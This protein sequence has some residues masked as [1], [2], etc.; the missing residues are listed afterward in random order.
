MFQQIFMS[1]INQKA[2]SI[3]ITGICGVF[4]GLIVLSLFLVLMNSFFANMEKKRIAKGIPV[5]TDE[6]VAAIA[7]SLYLDLSVLDEDKN[8][9]LTVTKVA[10]PYTPWKF[11]RNIQT[12]SDWKSFNTRR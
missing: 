8:A 12:I 5:V 4:L 10:Q 3:S 11:S 2:I 7:A 9:K 1:V 6:I